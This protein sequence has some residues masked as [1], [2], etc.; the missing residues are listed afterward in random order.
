MNRQDPKAL[1]PLLAS[2]KP[3]WYVLGALLV[4][5]ILATGLLIARPAVEAPATGD[6]AAPASAP[7]TAPVA[8]T[9]YGPPGLWFPIPGARLPASDD[10]LPGAPR[11]YRHGVSQGFDFY[12]QDA[13]V[14]IVSG[15][16][17]VAAQSAQIV[18]AD[19]AYTE[20]DPRAWEVLMADVAESGASE[21]QLDRLRGRQV[22]LRMAD[23]TVLRYGHLSAV[24]DGVRTGMNVYRGQVIGFAG[25]SGTDVAV[26]GRSD[27]TRLRFEIWPDEDNFFGAGME[28]EAVRIAAASLFVGP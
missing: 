15:T 26:A 3:G 5:A 16:P 24:R 7:A 11:A 20:I 23:G 9:K 25:N 10:H 6:V 18:R 27:Q 4:Y 8:E 22:W 13:S 19:V 2:V 21:D 17:V 28:P 1:G 14:P 12:G